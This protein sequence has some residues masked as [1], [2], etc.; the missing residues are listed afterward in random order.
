MF[1]ISRENAFLFQMFDNI[2]SLEFIRGP[3][4]E[5]IATTMISGEGEIMKFRTNVSLI[6]DLRFIPE[7]EIKTT[8]PA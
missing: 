7:Y 4:N 3:A 8:I 6:N 1:L 2:A 5:M